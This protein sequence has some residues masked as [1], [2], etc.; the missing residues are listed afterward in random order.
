MKVIK[1]IDSFIKDNNI[2]HIFLDIDG[3]MQYAWVREKYAW[4]VY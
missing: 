2:T 4:D 3:V 1:D